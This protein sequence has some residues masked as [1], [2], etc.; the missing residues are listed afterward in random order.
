[1]ADTNLQSYAGADK[2]QIS[3]LKLVGSS[4]YDDI[5]KLSECRDCAFKQL[6][7]MAHDARENACDIN[8]R[9]EGI[10]IDG[11]V[12]EGG[13]QC[14]IVV[15]GGSSVTLRNGVIIPH[16]DAAYDIELGGWSDQSMQRSTL[17]LDN[18]HRED[19]RPIRIV[20]GWW[21]RPHIVAN[22]PVEILWLRSIAYHAYNTFF[23]ICASVGALFARNRAKNEIA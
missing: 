23:Y 15:K 21:S 19:Q 6:D 14:S 7:V 10:L 11:F 20:C 18:V 13:R 3:G 17:I 1:V 12:F 8:N 16:S 9:C 22:A 2:L 5:F 4:A